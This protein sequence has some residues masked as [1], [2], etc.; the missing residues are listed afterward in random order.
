[1]LSLSYFL[2]L[3]FSLYFTLDIVPLTNLK[4]LTI[5]IDKQYSDNILSFSNN[6]LSKGSNYSVTIRTNCQFCRFNLYVYDGLK[7]LNSD[8]DGK[9][10]QNF[11]ETK[12]I[13]GK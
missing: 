12:L 2:C 11:L 8:I 10:F 13:T 9:A 1:M 7:I 3:L 4:N 5:N 6:K